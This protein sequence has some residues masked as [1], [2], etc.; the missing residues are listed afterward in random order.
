[1]STATQKSRTGTVVSV[2]MQKTVVVSV[3]WRQKH[4]LYGKAM[5]RISKFYAHD[6]EA[7][8]KLGDVVRIVETHP[9][10]KTKRWRVM[11]IVKRG[12]APEV[13]PA[14]IGAPEIRALSPVTQGV[15]PALE[16]QEIT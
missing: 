7:E 16:A 3:V 2:K 15:D 5:R 12:E 9:L 10:S 1:M 13:K 6:E 8:C 11:E 4:L 14:E